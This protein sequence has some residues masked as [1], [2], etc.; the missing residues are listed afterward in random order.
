MQIVGEALHQRHDDTDD[1]FTIM[2]SGP[3]HRPRFA[4]TRY[5]FSIR[6]RI[7]AR[8][9]N[10]ADLNNLSKANSTMAKDSRNHSSSP[11]RDKPMTMA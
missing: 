4:Q 10:R 8:T 9:S 7:K 1:Q 5:K 2:V 3:I 11:M 6:G